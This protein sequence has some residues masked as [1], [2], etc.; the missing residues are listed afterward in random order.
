VHQ[1]RG[2]LSQIIAN[3][4]ELERASWIDKQTRAVFLTFNLYNPNVNL[5][6][7][8]SLLLEIVPPI[9]HFVLQASFYPVKLNHIYANFDIIYF[10]IY[11]VL[12]IYYI[13]SEIRLIMKLR[14]VYIHHFWSYINWAIIGCS[15]AILAIQVYRQAEFKRIGLFFNK[16]K[17]QKPINLQFFTYFDSL[18]IYL[19]GFCC[20]FGTIKL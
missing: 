8:C 10:I 4:S 17:G 13:V 1:L 15:W 19:L 11:Y 3:L 20:F 12:I 5:F 9:N 2:S 16:Y 7:Y 14:R 6:T 18:L